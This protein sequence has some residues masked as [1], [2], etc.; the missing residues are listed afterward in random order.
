MLETILAAL[1]MLAVLGLAL[2]ALVAVPLILVGLVL[3]LLV[4]LVLLPFRALGWLFSAL[5]AAAVGVTKLVL[6][7]AA[8]CV[9]ILLVIGGVALLPLVPLLLL[10]GMAWLA[11]RL[12]RTP[13]ATA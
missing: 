3:K 11:A 5:G 9:M 1:V 8:G 7:L 13:R 12:L 4:A 10:V 6:G 2:V